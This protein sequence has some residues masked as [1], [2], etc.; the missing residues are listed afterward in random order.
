MLGAQDIGIPGP[1]TPAQSMQRLEQLHSE[2][3]TINHVATSF[4]NIVQSGSLNA[5]VESWNTGVGYYKEIW[6]G[7]KSAE[8]NKYVWILLRDLKY[9]PSFSEEWRFRDVVALSP[10]C[11]KLLS[12]PDPPGGRT[13]SE[14]KV[15]AIREYLLDHPRTEF[16]ITTGIYDVWVN[17][18]TTQGLM[19]AFKNVTADKPAVVFGTEQLCWMGHSC[20]E[21]QAS[22]WL[23][24]LRRQTNRNDAKS[25]PNNQYMGKRADVLKFLGH[26]LG[27]KPADRGFPE[28][29]HE[30]EEEMFSQAMIQNPGLVT[31][32]WGEVIFASMVRGLQEDYSFGQ[33]ICN[34]GGH[35]SKRCDSP[36]GW[37]TC[38]RDPTNTITVHERESRRLIKPLIW[39]LNGIATRTIGKAE[40]C[41]DAFK[42][43]RGEHGF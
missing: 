37:G 19:S 21:K 32:D 4:H 35:Q 7:C 27:K 28:K 8:M 25:F 17:R 34:F 29:A 18:I 5:S 39:S 10:I 22:D 23:D 14:M 43:T 12:V 33:Y 15:V 2:E 30:S 24:A 36:W 13:K 6:S 41:Y 38:F 26:A 1:K 40:M 20:S 16:I 3:D 9:H 11:V 42:F 31:I